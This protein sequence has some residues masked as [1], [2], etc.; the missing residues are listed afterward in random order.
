M[1]N[2][3]HHTYKKNIKE[4]TATEFRTVESEICSRDKMIR[5]SLLQTIYVLTLY[6]RPSMHYSALQTIYALTPYCRP[7][8]Y[9]AE[10]RHCNYL[11]KQ[12]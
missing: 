7:S 6:C 2:A 1:Q 8:I 11:M 12:K 5:N 10:N 3:I 9:S 4:V